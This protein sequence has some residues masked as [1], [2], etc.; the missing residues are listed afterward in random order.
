LDTKW[1]A[2]GRGGGACLA[3]FALIYNLSAIMSDA[4]MLNE[5]YLREQKA[6]LIEALDKLTTQI[7]DGSIRVYLAFQYGAGSVCI[8]DGSDW[9]RNTD[10]VRFFA[11][12]VDSYLRD[13]TKAAA[14]AKKLNEINIELNAISNK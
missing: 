10:A 11:N 1:R 6:L 8:G 12:N 14:L 13:V 3:V 7:S 2:T 5:M 4:D 9:A